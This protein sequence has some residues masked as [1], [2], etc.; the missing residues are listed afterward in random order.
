MARGYILLRDAIVHSKGGDFVFCDGHAGY[1]KSWDRKTGGL[2]FTGHYT[3]V[4][5]PSIIVL[6]DLAKAD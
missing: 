5:N 6:L 1:R 4:G 3:P 2:V